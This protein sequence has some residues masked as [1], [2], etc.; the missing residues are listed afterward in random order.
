MHG[1]DCR[2]TKSYTQTHKSIC[3]EQSIC[4]FTK[5]KIHILCEL[6]NIKILFGRISITQIFGFINKNIRCRRQ[7]RNRQLK[8]QESVWCFAPL[9]LP[10]K[11]GAR[12][13]RNE[14]SILDKALGFLLLG[15][16]VIARLPHCVYYFGKG[17]CKKPHVADGTLSYGLRWLRLGV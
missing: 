10:L 2:Q 8:K 6:K 12:L 14:N 9:Q 13:F 16:G 7:H 11:R 5:I 3:K 17:V 4:I 15:N 1:S